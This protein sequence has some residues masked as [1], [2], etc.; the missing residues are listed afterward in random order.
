LYWEENF[1]LPTSNLIILPGRE[2]ERQR[3]REKG[4]R[5]EIEIKESR[6]F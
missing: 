4:R 1:D 5:G 3:E 6:L 2:R